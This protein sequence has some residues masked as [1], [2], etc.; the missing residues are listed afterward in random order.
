MLLCLFLALFH[1]GNPKC[2]TR[3]DSQYGVRARYQVL[4]QGVA[5]KEYYKEN[6]AK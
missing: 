6:I 4:Y 5:V 2:Y 3:P 1:P